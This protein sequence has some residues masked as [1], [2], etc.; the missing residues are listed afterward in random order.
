[1]TSK[2]L[3]E[4]IAVVEG[5]S[6]NN[7][8]YSAKELNLFAPSLKNRPMLKDHNAIIDNVVGK[9]TFSE[10]IDN[11]KKVRYKGWIKDDGNGLLEKIK[12]GRV[13]EVSIGASAK[14]LLKEKEDDEVV[15]AE[16]LEALELSLVPVPGVIGT[17]VG[18]EQEDYNEDKLKEMIQDYEITESSQ[19]TNHIQSE[20]SNESKNDNQIKRN[21]EDKIKM[22]SNTEQKIVENTVVENAEV[23][24]LKEKL[25]AAEKV[26]T[27]MKEAQR[28]EALQMYKK[29]CESKKLKVKELSNASIE[30]IKALIEMA[31]EVEVPEEEEKTEEPVVEEKAKV[32]EKKEVA[33]PKTQEVA[34]MPIT[35]NK[36]DNYVIEQSELGGWAFFKMY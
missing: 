7:V 23:K 1:M 6:R 25:D 15:Y 22:E 17:S 5:T 11:G 24:M 28:Q 27:E 34:T 35:E 2:L 26:V 9:I 31:D 3:V 29:V 8:H 21:K 13:S 36:F 12:D 20:I 14:R 10:S 33:M 18:V 32:E 30:T 19:I 4:G 16:G